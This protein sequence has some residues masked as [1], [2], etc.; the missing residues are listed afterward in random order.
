[1]VLLVIAIFALIIFLE[2]FPL[3]KQQQRRELLA[4]SL[5]LAAGLILSL[6]ILYRVEFPYLSP[7]ISDLVKILVG[8][9]FGQD[10]GIWCAIFIFSP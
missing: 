1:M 6:L 4:A 10:M 8:G 9:L 3:S 5:L 2:I 7:A